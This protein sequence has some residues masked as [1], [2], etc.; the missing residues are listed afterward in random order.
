MFP[1]KE[2]SSFEVG[3]T[4]TEFVRLMHSQR[5]FKFTENGSEYNLE[6]LDEIAKISVGQEGIR[7]VALMQ[8]PK[9]AIDIDL[10][11]MAVS[12]RKGFIKIFFITFH[13]GGG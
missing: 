8:A 9:L 6:Y 12:S 1:G 2:F 11:E 13:K 4:R 10:K 5:N 3:F 7:R